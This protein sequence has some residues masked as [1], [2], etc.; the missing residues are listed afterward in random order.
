M[1]KLTW[2][3]FN[4]QGSGT[5]I[6]ASCNMIGNHG[7]YTA[8]DSGHGTGVFIR[9]NMEENNFQNLFLALSLEPLRCTPAFLH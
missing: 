7:D 4:F 1:E 9:V 5:T 2:V 6:F 8:Y 3:V